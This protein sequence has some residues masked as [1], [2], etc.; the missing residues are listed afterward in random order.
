MT[1]RSPLKRAKQWGLRRNAA[2]VAGNIGSES[3][4][5]ALLKVL[6]EDPDP[7]LR[8]HAVWAFGK[9]Q[10]RGAV[11]ALKTILETELDPEVRNEIELAIASSLLG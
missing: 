5:S 4:V 1:R 11:P 9:I 7:M 2:I 10:G 6:T 3:S 8:A